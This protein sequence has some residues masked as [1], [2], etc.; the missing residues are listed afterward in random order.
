MSEGLPS[1]DF[2]RKEE[3]QRHQLL[4]RQRETERMDQRK[5][6]KDDVGPMTRFI[7]ISKNVR[8]IGEH[9]QTVQYVGPPKTCG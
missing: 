4:T 5:K 3:Q 8:V 2:K 1:A 6:G 7:P 9:A